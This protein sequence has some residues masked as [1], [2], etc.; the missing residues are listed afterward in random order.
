MI[1][2]EKFKE[3]DYA[4]NIWRSQDLTPG[5]EFFNS[6]AISNIIYKL[7]L[8]HVILNYKFCTITLRLR[9]YDSNKLNLLAKVTCLL[10]K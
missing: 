2:K 3:S 6:H 1:R 4:T 7:P 10:H 9:D 5:F 8:T